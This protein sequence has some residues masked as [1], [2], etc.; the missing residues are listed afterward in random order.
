MGPS[1][2]LNAASLALK[3]SKVNPYRA[4]IE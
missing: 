1:P 2:A 4:P 3:L